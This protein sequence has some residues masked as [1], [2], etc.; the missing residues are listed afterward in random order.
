MKVLVRRIMLTLVSFA[1]LASGCSDCQDAHL[2]KTCSARSIEKVSCTGTK[3]VFKEIRESPDAYN[4]GACSIGTIQCRRETETREDYCP[5]GNESCLSEWTTYA[6]FEEVCIGYK[7]PEEEKCGN[8]LDDDCDGEVN[9]GYDLDGDGWENYHKKDNDGN[10]CGYDCND[11]DASVHPAATEVCDGADNNCNCLTSLNRDTN[12]DGVECGCSDI[13]CDSNVDEQPDG[14]PIS[15]LEETCYRGISSA[16]IVF[17]DTP[18]QTG[19]LMCKNG[20]DVCEGAKGPEIELCDGI[21][22]DCDGD[23]D[24]LVVG[25]GY[26]CGSDIGACVSGQ[27]V[28]NPLT[29]DMICVGASVGSSPD[30]CNGLDDDCDTEVD[31]DAEDVLCQNGC[32]VYGLQYCIDGEYSVCDAPS[33]V[34]EDDEPCNG[35]DDD[36]DGQ[37]DEGQE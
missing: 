4:V 13:G 30:I 34:D 23:I 7:A 29:A 37:I 18:C 35:L 28:C 33:P 8:D 27:L 12:N 6:Q 1:A 26:I 32:P 17:T 15:I 11:S 16:D 24:E 21:D 2:T 19:V 10:R 5:D 20:V 22:N 3:E 31:E 14:S 9:E 25:E 36:C